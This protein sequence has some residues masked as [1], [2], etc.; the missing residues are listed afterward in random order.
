MI[1][2]N[3]EARDRMLPRLVTI[4]VVAISVGMASLLQETPG[5]TGGHLRI[6]VLQLYDVVL[7]VL[8]L[9]GAPAAV[10]TI[11][12]S[13]RRPGVMAAV[14]LVLAT[15]ISLLFHPSLKGAFILFRLLAGLVLVTQVARMSRAELRRRV[16]GPMM[17]V[18]LFQGLLASAQLLTS[19]ALGTAGIGGGAPSVV[20]GV[21]R[22]PGTIGHPYVLAA[23]GLLALSLAVAFRPKDRSVWWDAG[24]AGAVIPVAVS[25]G[26]SVVIGYVLLVL[27]LGL[28]AT[29]DRYWRPVVA[30]AVLGFALPTIFFTGSWL[31]RVEQPGAG[32]SL[33]LQENV[34]YRLADDALEL[35]GQELLLGLG[36][37]QYSIELERRLP[38]DVT[39]AYPVHSVPL[40]VVAE[41]GLVLGGL[42]VAA[43]ARAMVGVVRTGT[44][45]WLLVAAPAGL[46]AFDVLHIVNPTGS[47]IFMIWLGAVANQTATAE[48]PEPSRV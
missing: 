47:I 11:R 29:R 6:V 20:N 43:V 24:P 9:I 46:L 44:R 3:T 16:V 31:T 2:L 1:L 14:V 26:R 12:E 40:Y 25:F 45:G 37:G 34:R 18:A 17:V 33:G 4:V 41:L 30:A 7:A 42:V 48:H 21:T 8:L 28:A 22:A 23:Y 35:I 39:N 38:V 13:W 10:D 32:D 27:V 15:G 19:S 5:I 36:S